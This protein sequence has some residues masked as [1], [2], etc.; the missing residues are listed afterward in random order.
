V[1]AR[2]RAHGLAVG[3][4]FNPQTSPEEAAGF[5]RRAAAEVVLCMSI[6]PGY[7]GQAFMPDALG[8]VA[9]LAELVSLPIQVDGG[10]GEDNVPAL[11]AAGASLLV[12]GSAVFGSGDPA[13]AYRRLVAL[14]S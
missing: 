7:S 10:V 13:G 4:V 14:A 9:R 5:A 6:E 2:A 1:A 11:R 8:R 3:A 12:A